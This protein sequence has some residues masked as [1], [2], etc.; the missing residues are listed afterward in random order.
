[1]SDCEDYEEVDFE[2]EHEDEDEED[3]EEVDYEDE[4]E[5]CED[6]EYA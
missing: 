1:M 4:D 3:F 6:Y 5:D 2:D